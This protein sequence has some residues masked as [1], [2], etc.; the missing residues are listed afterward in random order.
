MNLIEINITVQATATRLL[1]T[2]EVNCN[3]DFYCGEYIYL[4]PMQIK[5]TLKLESYRNQNAKAACTLA[6]NWPKLADF[7]IGWLFLGVQVFGRLANQEKNRPKSILVLIKNL[8]KL[9][10]NN[11]SEQC[12]NSSEWYLS[13]SCLFVGGTKFQNHRLSCLLL[14]KW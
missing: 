14:N 6:E 1:T 2:I 7:L 9:G 8:P 4:V 5:V 13:D 11:Q 10:C 12:T 3:D